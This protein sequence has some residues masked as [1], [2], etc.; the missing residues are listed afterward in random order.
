MANIVEEIKTNEEI[1]ANNKN[2]EVFEA[3]MLALDLDKDNDTNQYLDSRTS[4]HVTGDSTH[5]N[6]FKTKVNPTIVKSTLVDR[7][8]PWQR[9]IALSH[10]EQ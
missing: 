4:T 3:I 8:M 6:K 10:N 1:G 2:L 5:F 7:P 9:D